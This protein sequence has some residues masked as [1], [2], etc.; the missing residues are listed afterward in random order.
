MRHEPPLPEDENLTQRQAAKRLFLIF[1]VIALAALMA[2]LA[3]GSTQAQEPAPSGPV[4]VA[5][6]TRVNTD[7][8]NPHFI[9]DF[10]AMLKLLGSA[11]VGAGVLWG[12]QAAAKRKPSIDEELATVTERNRHTPS[13]SDLT[14][15][16][17]RLKTAEGSIKRLFAERD[18]AEDRHTKLAEAIARLEA[19][20]QT[21]TSS[22]ADI[23]REIKG[24]LAQQDL[25]HERKHS[26]LS[27]RVD[28]VLSALAEL[29]SRLPA[30]R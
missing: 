23:R 29:A 19:N 9:T 12:A 20:Q 28:K 16:N 24:D 1:V 21:N 4:V 13:V 2:F 25:M 10:L 18:E 8:I 17:E 15:M 30:K 3:V 26:T 11:A 14:S 27:D 6:H 5:G 22:I 7:E